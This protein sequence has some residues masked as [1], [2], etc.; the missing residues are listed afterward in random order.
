MQIGAKDRFFCLFWFFNLTFLIKR[1]MFKGIRVANLKYYL[2]MHAIVLAW[3]F[4]GILG[5]LIHLD[6]HRIVFFRMLI[7]ALSLLLFLTLTG[8]K[9]YIKDKRSLLKV[10]GVGVVVVLHWLTFFKAIQISSVSVVVLC[11]STTALHVS[12][13]EPL[14]MRRKFSWIEFSLGLLMIFGVIFINS[15]IDG[16]QF[17]GML[18]GLLSAFLSACF[19]VFNA[20]LNKDGISSSSLTVYEMLTGAVI[21]LIWFGFEGKVNA[22]LFA[23]TVNDFAWLL[24]L[25]VVC[26]SVAFMLMIDVVYRIGAYTATLTVNLEPIYSIVLAIIILSEDSFLGKQFYIGAVFIVAIVFANPLLK[27][28]RYKRQ[29]K[30]ALL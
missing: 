26:T 3:G 4:T 16:S 6:F 7:A 30:R 19:A 27:N 20:R 22:S 23:M 21:L 18:W 24:F 9:F 14:I 2:M 15:N 11:L 25:G 10:M 28:I 29:K 1:V 17:S 12:W 8:K 5:K 13:L